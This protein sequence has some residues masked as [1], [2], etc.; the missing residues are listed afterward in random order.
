[1]RVLFLS[2][3][4]P[5]PPRSGGDLRTFHL[6]R[7]LAG[8]HDVTLATFAWERPPAAPPFP[9]RIRAV[10]WAWPVWPTSSSTSDSRISTGSSWSARSIC[11]R[12]R[13]A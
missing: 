1:M 7:A 9:L 11:W 10:P 8:R 5:F 12:Y 13:P 3:R 6:L 4:A 2:A